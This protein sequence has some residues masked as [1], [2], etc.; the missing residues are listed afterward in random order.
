MK[1]RNN[2]KGHKKDGGTFIAP[3]IREGD[4]ITL[5]Y[6]KQLAEGELGE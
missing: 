6:R 4:Y 5:R 2:Y 1:D 3:L